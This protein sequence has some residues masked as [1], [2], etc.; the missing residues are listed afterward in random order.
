MD[1]VDSCPSGIVAWIQ[2][3]QTDKDGDGCQDI[4]EDFDDD[5]DGYLD[6]EDQRPNTFGNSTVVGDAG[7][8]SDG[9]GRSDF[10]DQFP[11]DASEWQDSDLDQVGDNADPFAFDATQWEDADGDGH[12]DN[13][14][15]TL[16]TN[17]HLTRNDGKIQMMMAMPMRMTHSLM[18]NHSGQTKMA[19]DMAML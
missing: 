9:D 13:P 3:N 7:V 15:G 18:K 2:N 12:G 17:F 16:E 10:N 5:N 6:Q 4:S 11:N 14:Y 19:T 8:D 1:S